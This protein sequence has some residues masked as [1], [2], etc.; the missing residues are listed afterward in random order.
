[1]IT[2][3][4]KDI[5]AV[6]AINLAYFTALELNPKTKGIVRRPDSENVK[7]ISLGSIKEFMISPFTGKPGTKEMWKPKNWDI[8]YPVVM[9]GCF[10]IY[11]CLGI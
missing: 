10:G 9:T 3:I 5:V 6:G 2:S 1:M 4:I 8:N 7:H 11:K